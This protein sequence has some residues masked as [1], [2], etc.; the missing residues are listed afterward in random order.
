M[1]GLITEVSNQA[2]VTESERLP[3]VRQR[4]LSMIKDLPPF[5]GPSVVALLNR[6]L[7]EAWC[8]LVNNHDPR[9]LNRTLSRDDVAKRIMESALLGQRDPSRLKFE[10]MAKTRKGLLPLIRIR[11]A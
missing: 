4:R 11:P 8:E 2:P 7:E 9:V 3:P 6:V 1:V 5:Y 10:A